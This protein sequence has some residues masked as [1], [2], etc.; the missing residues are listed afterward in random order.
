MP[1]NNQPVHRIRLGLINASIFANQ[2]ELGRTFHN[3]QFDR[4]YKDG[5]D[6]KNTRSFGRDDLLVL[7]KLADLVHTWICEEQQ[8]ARGS[9]ADSAPRAAHE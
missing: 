3:A 1:N 4:A 7:S 9:E 6:W 8:Q 5:E 2:S